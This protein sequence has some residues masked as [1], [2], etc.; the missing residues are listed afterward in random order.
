MRNTRF[1]S[2]VAL[3]TACASA[4]GV[5]VAELEDAIR[6]RI[7]EQD[8]AEVSVSLIDLQRNTELHIDGDVVMHAASTMKV[9]VLLE[10]FHQAELGQLRLDSLIT[11]RN[12]FQSIADTSHY[13]LDPGDDSDSSVYKLD[14]QRVTVRDLARRMIVRSSNLGTNILIDL[15]KPER[16]RETVAQ[17]GAQGMT[18]LRGVE[19]MPAFSKGMN[20]TTTS[21]ALARLLAVIAR[22]EGFRRASCDEMLSILGAQE[23]NGM[24][25]AGLPPGT[26]VAHKTGSITRVQHDG[27][28]VLPPDRRPY[29]LVVLTRGIADGAV[30]ERLGADISR[31]VWTSLTSR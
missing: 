10:I 8:S 22:C 23:F 30:A 19:D 6:A 27:A 2:L 5:P 18:V 17:L 20:N 29:V 24:I 4:R 15:V 9:P 14:G 28:I 31:I 21:R 13:T 16:V 25:P 26:R 11:V 12:Y 7:A 1:I 3:S